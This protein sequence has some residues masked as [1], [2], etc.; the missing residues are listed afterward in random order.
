[1]TDDRTSVGQGRRVL[2]VDD[3]ETI[4][5]ATSMYFAA[6]GYVVDSAREREEA[7]ALLSTSRY[8][9]VI[10]DMRLTGVHGREGL[11]LIG[12]V[13]ERCPWAKVI[14]LT[15]YVS[16]ELAEEA[17][18]R[19]ADLFLEKPAPLSDLLA[20]ASRLIGSGA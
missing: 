8:A 10:A 17:Q 18:R 14:V 9:L 16:D 2:V 1:M 11:E 6:H 19:G 4:V 5:H 13:R 12:F 15:G 7:E 20:V 3:E